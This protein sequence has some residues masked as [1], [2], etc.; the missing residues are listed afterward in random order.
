MKTL[1]SVAHFVIRRRLGE[2][3][4]DASFCGKDY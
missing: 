4:T 3:K 1:I 2:P